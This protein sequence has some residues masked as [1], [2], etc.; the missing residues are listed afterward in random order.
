MSGPADVTKSA[1]WDSQK[2]EPDRHDFDFSIWVEGMTSTQ[3]ESLGDAI[4]DLLV[5]SGHDWAM[6]S[7]VAP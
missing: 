7:Q 4:A 3:R 5:A 6:S 2:N 1:L